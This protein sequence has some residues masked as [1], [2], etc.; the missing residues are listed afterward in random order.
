MRNNMQRGGNK[1]LKGRRGFHFVLISPC[2]GGTF[3]APTRSAMPAGAPQAR[4]GRA[5]QPMHPPIVFI[6]NACGMPTMVYQMFCEIA[7]ELKAGRPNL[8]FYAK[9]WRMLC[10]K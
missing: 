1:I 5:V 4:G 8:C 6:A 10:E 7:R 2:A 9:E 3:V